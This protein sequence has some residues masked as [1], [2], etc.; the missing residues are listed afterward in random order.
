MATEADHL[1]ADIALPVPPQRVLTYT[2]PPLLQ[3]QV[4]VGERALVPL[5]PR[6]V[7]GYIVGLRSSGPMDP[8]DLKPIDAIL[9]P[10]P[11]LDHHMLELTRLVA[12]YYLTSWGLVIRTALP[13][14]IDRRTVR[15]VE[16]IGSPE[17][18]IQEV[19]QLDPTQ[20]QILTI[21]Q[22]RRRMLMSSLKRCWSANAVDQLIRTLVNCNLARLTYRDHPPAVRPAC[23]SLLY[24][25]ANRATVKTELDA[26][27]KRAP[28][29]ALL[30]EHLLA[31]DATI[32]SA[33]AV[34]LAGAS[35]VRGLIAKGLIRRITEEIERSPWEE[36]VVVTDH[37]PELN[38]A[39]QSAVDGLLEGLSLHTFFPALLYG[40]TGSGKTE[41]YLR[42]IGEVVRQ[43][44]QA[45]V[46]VPEIALTPVAADRFRSRFGDR[47]ALLHSGLSPGE[48]LDQWRRIK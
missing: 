36:T 13:P 32:S 14:G 39:Q 25:P 12:D 9:D 24:L 37:R 2:L 48:R 33:E 26:L 4:E 44:R 16:L 34:S 47:V 17:Q 40:T 41:V 38:S 7:T 23:R 5:G 29:Q 35:G 22:A 8:P 42:V 21:L 31:T 10:E 20:R 18:I 30:L 43:G 27:R 45:L 11:L 3:K 19:S 15:T 28:R 6:L 1:L 46:L